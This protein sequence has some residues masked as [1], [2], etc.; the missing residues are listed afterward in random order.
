MEYAMNSLIQGMTNVAGCYAVPVP[1]ST[2]SWRRTTKT[3]VSMARPSRMRLQ[4]NTGKQQGSG[5]LP[6]PSSGAGPGQHGSLG[7]L[8]LTSAV[9]KNH[10]SYK[11]P[12][13]LNNGKFEF[14]RLCRRV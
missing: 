4:R 12:V 2:R 14:L 7:A 9:I 10:V 6:R 3:P 8:S 1:Q 13:G 5:S 11:L